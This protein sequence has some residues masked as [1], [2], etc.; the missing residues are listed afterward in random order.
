MSNFFSENGMEILLGAAFIV[1]AMSASRFIAVTLRERK[2]SLSAGSGNVSR[3]K[4]N[5]K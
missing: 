5:K 4:N 3:K 2:N 1:F